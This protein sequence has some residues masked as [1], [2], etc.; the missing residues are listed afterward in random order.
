[1]NNRETGRNYE[2]AAANY[3]EQKGY[4][5]IARNFRSRSAEIDIVALDG[6]YLVFAEVKQRTSARRG[7]GSQAVDLRKQR[8]I[9]QAAAWYMHRYRCPAG[10]PV[11]FDVVSIDGSRITLLRN[12]FEWTA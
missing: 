6:R 12:A 9:C 10:T 2:D 7:Y 11:R 8:R 1:M 4:R 3:L 5:I